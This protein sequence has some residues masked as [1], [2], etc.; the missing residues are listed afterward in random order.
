MTDPSDGV[1][2]D[3]GQ[4]AVRSRPRRI[5]TGDGVL[6][7]TG[8]DALPTDEVLVEQRGQLV[9]WY[10]A[11]GSRCDD[12]PRRVIAVSFTGLGEK[13][14]GGAFPIAAIASR[15]EP[16]PLV[17]CPIV[18][19]LA[20]TRDLL[21]TWHD[22]EQIHCEPIQLHG[23]TFGMSGLSQTSSSGEASGQ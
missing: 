12:R 5:G 19:L 20:C 3:D 16:K 9:L 10:T 15:Q 21:P 18:D 1:D 6:D 22:L 8:C 11:T 14:R 7:L 2:V 17:Q 23:V 13:L 4:E